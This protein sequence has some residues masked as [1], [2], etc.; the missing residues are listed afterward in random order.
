MSTLFLIFL[1]WLTL[2]FNYTRGT[3]QIS[4]TKPTP[5]RQNHDESVVIYRICRTIRP[6]KGKITLNPRSY[7]GFA[8]QSWPRKTKI[9]LNPWLLTGFSRQ[10]S[11][12]EKTYQ[13]RPH[14]QVLISTWN[15][16]F[17]I[18]FNFTSQS[19]QSFYHWTVLLRSGR[20][21]QGSAAAAAS[22]SSA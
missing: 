15:E 20:W 3:N 6:R 8:K 16:T 11:S 1:F 17:K 22:G 10:I 5:E 12:M 9:S 21:F 7:T 2:F 18:H 19:F 13:K 4:M 14:I